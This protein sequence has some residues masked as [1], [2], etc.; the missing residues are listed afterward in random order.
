MIYA[1]VFLLSFSV[2][3][4]AVAQVQKEV[5]TEAFTGIDVGSFFKVNLIKSDEHK[6]AFKAASDE[7]ERIEI[8]V[9]GNVLDISLNGNN[10]NSGSGDE[11]EI[12]VDVFYVNLNKID[13]GG[14]AEIDTKS[15]IVGEQLNIEAG[16][17]SDLEIEV[18]VKKLYS[19]ISGASNVRLSGKTNFHYLE[20]S[21]AANLRAY[22]LE[23]SSTEA[24]VSGAALAYVSATE[25]LTGTVSGVA[26]LKHDGEP[27]EIE[28]NDSRTIEKRIEKE[29]EKVHRYQDSVRVRVGK[30]DVQVIDSDTTTIK[31]GRSSIKIDDDGNVEIGKQKKEPSFDGHWAGFHMGVNGLMDKDQSLDMPAGYEK[32]DLTYEKSIN[33]QL[34]FYEQNFNLIRNKV[35]LVTGLGFMWDNYRF[36][37]DVILNNATDTLSF[38]TPAADRNYKKSK[39]VA[40]YLTLPFL[41]EFQTDSDNDI[42]SFHLAA[43]V[44]GGW[45]IGTHTKTVYNGNNK[46][47]EREDFYLNPFRGDAMVTLGWGK[48]NLYASYSL[49][50]LFKDEKGPELYPFNIGIHL[51]NF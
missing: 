31:M 30:F 8:S 29:V 44:V 6:V 26:K 23:T 33:V 35:G 37:D 43:G 25:K 42:N 4:N 38:T 39:L 3:H 28:I 11:D 5:K 14:V 18:D 45:R 34:N 19:D 7:M 27:E 40:T 50:P 24:S 9:K 17:A 13:A 46:N 36:E 20:V 12:V 32:L 1:L 22:G 51:I 16:G 21:G 2:G 49:I 41:L 15:P 47:K 48:L 10:Y